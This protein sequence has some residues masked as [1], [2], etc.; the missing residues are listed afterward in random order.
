M[1]QQPVMPP[2]FRHTVI[3]PIAG[4]RDDP[5]A[6]RG[7]TQWYIMC[8]IENVLYVILPDPARVKAALRIQHAVRAYWTRRRDA[9]ALAFA[10]GLHARLGAGSPVARLDADAVAAIVGL[11]SI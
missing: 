1:E 7:V 9:R 2:C 4:I 10:M 11:L 8:D 5:F 6:Q 3:V